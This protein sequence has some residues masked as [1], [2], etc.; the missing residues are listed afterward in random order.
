[1]KK[2][3]LACLFLIMLLPIL[4][5]TSGCNT[6]KSFYHSIYK[7]TRG[8]T[9]GIRKRVMIMPVI[10]Q[11]G[12]GEEKTEKMTNALIELLKKDGQLAVHKADRPSPGALKLRSPEFGITIDPDL[13]KRA[14]ELG[15]SVLITTILNPFE[16]SR[17]KT[18]IWPLR[19]LRQ[20]TEI[21]F[22]VN[23]VNLSNGTMFLSN[24]ESE[25]IKTP[26]DEFLL[27]DEEERKDIPISDELFNKA[28]N[29][30]LKDQAETILGSLESQAW[31]GRILSVNEK[32][33]II[34]AGKDVGLPADKI[35]EVFG[36]GDS[37]LSASGRHLFVLGPKIGELQTV[38]VMDTYSAAK[39]LADGPFRAGQIIRVKQ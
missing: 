9:D 28:V 4:I 11:A 15:M 1:M 22:L 13:A 18:G 25:T 2:K 6:T 29:R 38:K 26:L 8:G 37:I 17:K 32:T 16:I 21:S 35:F 5:Q 33:I 7:K 36:K 23:A 14:E 20:E 12:V 10:D 34:N 3:L 24:L 19:K 27:E 30:L 31:T 39:P